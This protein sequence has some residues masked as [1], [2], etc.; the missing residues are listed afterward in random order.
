MKSGT[1]LRKARLEAGLTQHQLARRLGVTQAALAQL[2]SPRANPTV[3]TL[4]RVLAGTGHRLELRATPA[5]PEID[6][7]LLREALRMSPADRLATLER[8]NR[9]AELL[10]AAGSRIRPDGA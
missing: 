7:G 1:V 8:L 2:E 10:A 4:E 9:D 3:A 6:V 5:P